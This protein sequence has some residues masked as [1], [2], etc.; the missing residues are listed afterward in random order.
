MSL[1]ILFFENIV[2]VIPAPLL[3]QMSFVFSLWILHNPAQTLRGT[4]SA[5]GSRWGSLTP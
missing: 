1:P 3:F 4:A 2:L 5:P